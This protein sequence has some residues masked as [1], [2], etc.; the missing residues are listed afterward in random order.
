MPTI[1]ILLSSC[2]HKILPFN[3]LVILFEFTFPKISVQISSNIAIP[4]YTIQVYSCFFLLIS[5]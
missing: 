1:S 5:S 4:N 3:F 2:R